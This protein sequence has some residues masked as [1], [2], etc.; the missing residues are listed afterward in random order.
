MAKDM[1][2]KKHGKKKMIT[3]VAVA[4]FV[5]G[6]LWLLQRLL[7]PKYASAVV[8]GNLIAEYYKE[9]KDH[10]VLF[11]GDCE[12]YENFVPAVLWENYGINSYIRGSAQQLIW[13]SYYLLEDAL[14]YEKPDVVVF[15]VLSMQYNEPQKE[16]YNRMSLEG[17]KWSMSKVNAIK[18]SMT[19]EENFLDYVFPILRYHSRITQLTG[20]D[21]RYLFSRPQVSYNGYYMRVDS[22]PAEN[23]PEGRK[24]ADYRFGDNAYAYLD[25]IT[26][27]CADNGIELILVKAPSL[28]PYWYDQWEE[29]M[30]EYAAAHGLKYINFLE[31]TQECGLDFSTDTYDAGLHLNLWGA[32]KI[33]NYLGE[34]LR[35]DCGL[36]DRRGQEHLAEVWEQKLEEYYAEIARQKELYGVK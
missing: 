24:L 10:D 6:T 16:A 8:E 30:E 5:L 19:E 36:E 7:E 9:E 13:Q 17:M 20:E 34:V 18:A 31:L 32:V 1:S 15:N 25:K 28:Y 12:V 11:I 29:Q 21:F 4:A 2:E 22:K 14:R 27:L 33:T 26:R 3:T 35:R 23:V